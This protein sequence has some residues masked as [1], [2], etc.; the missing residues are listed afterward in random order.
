MGDRKTTVFVDIDATRDMENFS[1]FSF[2]NSE[3]EQMRLVKDFLPQMSQNAVGMTMRDSSDTLRRDIEKD[4]IYP[5]FYHD[6]ATFD[7]LEVTMGQFFLDVAHYERTDQ[8]LCAVD[9]VVDLRLVPPIY[10]AE[11][12]PGTQ[13]SYHHEV[14]G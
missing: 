5:E 3:V 14:K 1:G 8:I 10:R 13:S 7:H 6:Y 2:K 4:I 11:M 12:S 9:G